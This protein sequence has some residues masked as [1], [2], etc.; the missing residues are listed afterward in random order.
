MLL[1]RDKFRESVFTR[2][3]R[4]CVLCGK[5]AVDAHHI[6]ERKLWDD[7]GY[8]VENG[9]SV[10][11]DCHILCEKTD[12]SVEELRKACSIEV[13]VIPPQLYSDIVY[14]KWG[15]VVLGNGTRLRGELFFDEQV[16]KILADKL[17]LFTGLVKYPRTYHLPWSPGITDD[18]RIMAGV[19]C[20]MGKRVV[21]TEKLDG[22]NT[23][24][25][26]DNI[27]ARSFEPERH[28][29][30]SWVKNF[31]STIRHDIPQGWRVC[32]ENLYAK[33][34]I[35]YENLESYLFG[36]SVWNEKNVCLS[37]DET[38]E[39]FDL[40]GIISVPVLFDGVFDEG[41]IKSLWND[42]MYDSTEGYV[43]RVADSF[44][45]G[46]FRN[47]VGKFVRPSHV[48]TVYNW[49]RAAFVKNEL[50]QK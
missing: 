30:R 47:S 43:V 21:V 39:W 3:S 48:N 12:V 46:S 16:Q 19:D 32:G 14:D 15:N 31:W 17:H 41:I 11:A 18:D 6:L 42:G 44:S 33:H 23:T 38:K 5:E 4:K 29:S 2:D 28:I 26:R 34:S 13:P 1:T 7:G 49:F 27:H 25:Y 36:F 37:W 35:F 22:E 40:L 10:C 50:R 8:Y 9:A 24:L 45:F 20:F